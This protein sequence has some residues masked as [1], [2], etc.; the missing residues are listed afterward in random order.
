M[1][2]HAEVQG[3]GNWTLLKIWN[4]EE[5]EGSGNDEAE[6]RKDRDRKKWHQLSPKSV[7]H[8]ELIHEY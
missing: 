6:Y 8:T 3:R 4:I 7:N 5:N 2:L 1:Q